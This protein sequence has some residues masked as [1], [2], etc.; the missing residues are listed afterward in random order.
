MQINRI[1]IKNFR[2][3]EEASIEFNEIT[4]FI[5]PNGAGKSTVLRALNWL[6]NGPKDSLTA[7]DCFG[8][9]SLATNSTIEVTVEF[10]DLNATDREV[11]T[12]R[13]APQQS[14]IFTVRRQWSLIGGDSLSGA[15]QGLPAFT[16][17]RLIA[18]G[19]AGPVKDAYAALRADLVD[20]GINLPA[21]TTKPAIQTALATWE[22]E[23]PERLETVYASDTQMFGFAGQGAIASIFNFIFVDADLRANDEAEDSSKT[24]IG[25]ILSRA[26]DR[27]AAE[28]ALEALVSRF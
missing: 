9:A 16:D 5:G 13:Y 15:T 19:P 28:D 24:I 7:S 27:K 12:Q 26:L 8:G 22:I 10:K 11:L 6:F 14:D 25:K 17:I 1:S 23:H 20:Q 2:C 4:S 3:I 18:D 21:A